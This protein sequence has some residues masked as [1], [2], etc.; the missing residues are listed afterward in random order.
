M[1][2]LNIGD[3]GIADLCSIEDK[4][5]TPSINEVEEIIFS[6]IWEQ[7]KNQINSQDLKKIC[8]EE[9]EIVLILDDDKEAK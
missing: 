7:M 2:L 5:V 3:D 8:I 4:W 9:P 6:H 1:T